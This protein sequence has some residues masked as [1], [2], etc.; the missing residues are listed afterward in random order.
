[1]SNPAIIQPQTQEFDMGQILQQNEE[2]SEV[3][4]IDQDD[5][6]VSIEPIDYPTKP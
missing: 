5:N 1:M 3:V 6:G 2:P 4:P